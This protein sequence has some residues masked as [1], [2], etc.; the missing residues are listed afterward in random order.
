MNHFSNWTPEDVERHNRRVSG[1]AAEKQTKSGLPEPAP[2]A[3]ST[4]LLDK[5]S[6]RRI[7]QRTKPMMNRLEFEF[8]RMQSTCANIMNIRTQAITFLIANGVRYTPDFTWRERGTN[9]TF[10]I[11]V[12]GPKAFDGSLEKLKMAAHEFPDW[13]W[14]LVWKDKD[15]IW[16]EQEV[17][18]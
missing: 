18:P 7:R 11:E 13:K 2:K 17:L 12:K 15:G 6:G 1:D 14:F 16:R 10:A 9:L 3:Q 8:Y 4:G 5:A